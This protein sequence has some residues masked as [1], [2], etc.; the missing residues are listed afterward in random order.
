MALDQL[1][2]LQLRDRESHFLQGELEG[3][4]VQPTARRVLRAIE[5]RVLREWRLQKPGTKTAPANR[6]AA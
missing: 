6:L 5:A 1:P 2:D 4:A 3:R